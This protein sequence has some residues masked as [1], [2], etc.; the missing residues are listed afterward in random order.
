M[1]SFKNWNISY[2]WNL[3]KDRR[4]LW[5]MEHDEKKYFCALYFCIYSINY[6]AYM[7]MFVLNDYF[8]DFV[9]YFTL[10]EVQMFSEEFIFLLEGFFFFFFWLPI[11]QL[12]ETKVIKL[13]NNRFIGD[14]NNGWLLPWRGQE[15][16][17]SRVGRG[18]GEKQH[19]NKRILIFMLLICLFLYLD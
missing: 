11:H 18:G 4:R 13:I 17:L 7:W 16:A 5:M 3:P 8:V 2:T 14:W 10:R 15:V 12:M 1:K 19:K 9:C 6:L